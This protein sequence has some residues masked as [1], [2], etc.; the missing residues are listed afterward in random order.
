LRQQHQEV[1]G[2][3]NQLDNQRFETMLETRQVLTPEQRTKMAELMEKR[4]HHH[5]G[6]RRQN[7]NR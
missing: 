7:S 2:L 5:G 1:Q 4:G 3:R 6:D